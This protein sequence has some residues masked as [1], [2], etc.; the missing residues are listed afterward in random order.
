MYVSLDCRLT[1]A[2]NLSSISL[3]IHLEATSYFKLSTDI[4]MSLHFS[5]FEG[6]NTTIQRVKNDNYCFGLNVD[7]MRADISPRHTRLPQS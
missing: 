7:Y 5:L 3:F 1:I 2:T 4:F 6:R